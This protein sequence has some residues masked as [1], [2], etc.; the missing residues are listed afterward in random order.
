MLE[1]PATFNTFIADIDRDTTVT[2]DVEG[3]QGGSIDH[4]HTAAMTDK[5]IGLGCRF[6]ANVRVS[7]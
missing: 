7:T 6:T 3:S 2:N 4:I 1:D 5:K